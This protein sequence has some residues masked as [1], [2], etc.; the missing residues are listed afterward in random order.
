MRGL[1]NAHR[2][3]I[4][5]QIGDWVFLKLEPY[6]QSSLA[7]SPYHKLTSQYFG[8]YPVVERVGG[9]PYTLLLP[10]KVL[11]HPTFHISQLKL[12]HSIPSEIIHPP[13]LDLSSSF[14]PVPELVLP[15]WLI[16]KGNKVVAQCLIKWTGLDTSYATCELASTL[17]ICFPS[18]SLEDKGVVPQGDVD[19]HISS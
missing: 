1:A 16:K 11:I 19:T 5:L 12:C 9:I 3:D 13:V 2:T 6:R 7:G 18:F 4:H 10:R 14:C 8:P 17:R 15:K